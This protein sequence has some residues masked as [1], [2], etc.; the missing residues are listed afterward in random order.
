MFY[1]NHYI[2]KDSRELETLVLWIRIILND[3]LFEKV[4]DIKFFGIIPFMNEI[5]PKKFE[6]GLEYAKGTIVELEKN[7]SNFGPLSLRFKHQILAH[8]IDTTWI[9]YKGSLN[10]GTTHDVFVLYCMI[11]RYTIN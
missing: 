4:C 11:K 7:L 2:F 1:A 3:I 5:W 6:V 8:I 9:P 10:N